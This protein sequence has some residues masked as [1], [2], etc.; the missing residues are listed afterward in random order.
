MCNK[1]QANC[2]Q[3]KSHLSYSAFIH[4]CQSTWL[5]DLCLAFLGSGAFFL[6]EYISCSLLHV[7]SASYMLQREQHRR[8]PPRNEYTCCHINFKVNF[9]VVC[10][11]LAIPFKP[12]TFE[13]RRI[14]S[15]RH[16]YIQILEKKGLGQ[17]RNPT[18]VTLH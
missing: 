6:S 15:Q 7:S 14:E 2:A 17:T 1:H 5:K 9:H 11:S 8:N 10:S 3:A 18:K 4:E 16:F 12:W 13:G